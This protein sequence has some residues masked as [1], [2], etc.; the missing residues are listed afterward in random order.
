LELEPPAA[1]GRLQHHVR[2]DE[3]RGHEVRGELDAGELQ[4]Q[5]VGD[6]PHQERLAEPRHAFEQHVPAGNEGRQRPLHDVVL[7]DDH[8]PDLRAEL[9][10]VGPEPVEVGLDRVGTHGGNPLSG[11]GRG[12]RGLESWSE[13]IQST[14]SVKGLIL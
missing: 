3:V 14:A 8:L 4:V 2:P 5:G 6:R 11:R 12:G 10:E 9:Q 1:A 13:A 7:A